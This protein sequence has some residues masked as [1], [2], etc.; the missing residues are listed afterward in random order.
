[1]LIALIVV[2]LAGGY[3]LLR[4]RRRNRSPIPAIPKPRKP[5]KPHAHN[6]FGEEEGSDDEDLPPGILVAVHAKKAAMRGGYGTGVVPAKYLPQKAPAFKAYGPHL[7]HH[8][9]LP[10]LP[11]ARKAERGR[12]PAKAA[13]P[14]PCMHV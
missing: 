2:P 4:H 5:K 7:H 6:A 13:G 1:M 3:A 14:K 8:V 10:H 11:G 9:H 12:R